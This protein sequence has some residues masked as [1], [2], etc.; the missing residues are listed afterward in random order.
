ML[1]RST[2]VLTASS[3]VPY[4]AA[5]PKVRV[6]NLIQATN[7]EVSVPSF[8][9]SYSAHDQHWVARCAALHAL[10]SHWYPRRSMREHATD[11]APATA[12]RGHGC[13]SLHPRRR[14]SFGR[15]AFAFDCAWNPSPRRASK[16]APQMGARDGA[17]YRRCVRERA[18]GPRSPVRG[19]RA[20]RPLQSWLRQM[21]RAFD[22]VPRALSALSWAV[23]RATRPLS[24][25]S[26]SG[27]GGWPRPPRIRQRA[28]G[29]HP[30]TGARE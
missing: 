2:C 16:R 17:S 12:A 29:K 1:F 24:I 15:S 6:L 11:S 4:H 25:H 21:T 7:V 20:E 18:R 26:H 5:R 30:A 28:L 8:P 10:S 19:L 23:A 22:R 14:P 9:A 27:L 13:P 3:R